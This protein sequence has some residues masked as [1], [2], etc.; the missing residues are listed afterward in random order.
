[1]KRIKTLFIGAILG[2]FCIAGIGQE[3]LKP[4]DNLFFSYPTNGV[5][6]FRA[7]LSDTNDVTI[8]A[9]QFLSMTREADGRFKIPGS[10]VYDGQNTNGVY[11]LQLTSFTDLIE[12][13]KS[14][15]YVFELN[16]AVTNVLA[17]PGTI[18]VEKGTSFTNGVVVININLN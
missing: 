3:L 8:K 2:L 14:E 13:P 5:T 10:V 12:S 15:P 4:N 6:S 18:T 9:Y 17:I 11:N 16:N 7:Y 1:M